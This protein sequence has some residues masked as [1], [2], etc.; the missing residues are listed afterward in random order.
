MGPPP[1]L[2]ECCPTSQ[3]RRGKKSDGLSS[4]PGRLDMPGQLPGPGSRAWGWAGCSGQRHGRGR[5]RE[6]IGALRQRLGFCTGTASVEV[7]WHGSARGLPTAHWRPEAGD[8]SALCTAPH[9]PWLP[10]STGC[11]V[12]PTQPHGSSGSCRAPKTTKARPRAPAEIRRMPRCGQQRQGRPQ[13]PTLTAVAGPSNTLWATAP[14]PPD[15]A[16]WTYCTNDVGL[17]AALDDL[18]GD[19]GGKADEHRRGGGGAG[20][21]NRFDHQVLSV[22]D[23]QFNSHV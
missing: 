3:Q 17:L 15:T 4:A 6:I 10:R 12:R 19:K 18:Q 13:E 14:L 5:G 11:V 2:A 7:P 20:K 9:L 23:R 21:L 1:R 8:R 16:D 22:I